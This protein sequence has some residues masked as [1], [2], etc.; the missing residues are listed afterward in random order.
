MLD[1]LMRDRT[2]EARPGGGT[3]HNPIFIASPQL[4]GTNFTL[5]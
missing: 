2:E 4:Q 3:E 5:V 1:V